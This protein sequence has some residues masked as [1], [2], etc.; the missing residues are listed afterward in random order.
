M[1]PTKWVGFVLNSLGIVSYEQGDAE[2]AKQ[3]FTEALGQ[4]R[5]IGETN[6][7]VYAL[8]NLGKIALA[9]GDFDQAAAYYQERLALWQEHGEETS[10]AGCL[11]GLAIIAAAIGKCEE[12][13]GLFGAAEALRERIGLPQAR[14]RARYEQAVIQCRAALGEE[15]M[16]ARW[17]KGRELSLEAAVAIGMGVMS[18]T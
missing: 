4:F 16:L 15:Q 11:R 14:H 13:A 3:L 6:S 8:T 17:H 9:R 18:T 1:E 7:T 5:T 10:V 12:A 2:R